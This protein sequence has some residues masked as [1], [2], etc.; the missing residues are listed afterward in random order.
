M[1]KFTAHHVAQSRSYYCSM[2]VSS[3]FTNNSSIKKVGSSLNLSHD[4]TDYIY[5][6]NTNVNQFQSKNHTNEC[7]P[8]L[9]NHQRKDSTGK[10]FFSTA[11]NGKYGVK[12]TNFTHI[13]D[14]GKD[15]FHSIVFF[16]Q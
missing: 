6:T 4:T 3:S 14:N 10:R 9:L 5:T 1:K 15:S 2:T 16:S 11:S 7:I 12:Q 8:G 13:H